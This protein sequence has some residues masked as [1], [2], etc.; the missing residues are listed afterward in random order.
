MN[1]DCS[2]CINTYK[3][4]ELLKKLLLSLTNQVLLENILLEKTTY[5]AIGKILKDFAIQEMKHA[6]T[7]MERIYYLGGSATTKASKV[8]VGNTLKEFAANDLKA[9]E[10]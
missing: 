10:A 6:G 7:I 2:C 8:V 3:R 1:I 4:P 5:D 9:E